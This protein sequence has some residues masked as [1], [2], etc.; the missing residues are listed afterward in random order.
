MANVVLQRNLY[1][2]LA[3]GIIRF[4]DEIQYRRGEV[5]IRRRPS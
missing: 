3:S 1:G 2:P 4:A 5:N